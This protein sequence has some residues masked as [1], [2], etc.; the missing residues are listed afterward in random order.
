MPEINHQLLH[1]YLKDLAGDA[2][3]QFAPVYL[4]FGEE[5]LVKTAYAELL[6]ALLPEKNRSANFYPV[7]GAVEN[8]YEVIERVNT[9][10]LIPGTKVVALL[11]SRIFYATQDKTRLIENSKKAY[12]DDNKI[13]AA[14][15]LLSL[16]GNLSLSYEDVDR[17][18]RKKTLTFAP[19]QIQSDDWLDDLIEYCRQNQL[20]IPGPA[21][22]PGAL[23]KAIKNGFPRNNHLVITTDVVDKR[24][25]LYKALKDQGVVVDCRVPKGD[26]RADRM[27]QEDVLRAK[28]A[29]VIEPVNKKVEES[30]YAALLDMTGFDLRT[31]CGNL[32]KLVDYVGQRNTITVK[33]VTSVLKRT[34][35]D[36]IY[37]L[38]NAIADRQ[39]SKTLFFVNT[40]LAGGFH[41]L[42]I[43]AAIINQVRKLLLAKD[44]ATSPEA[45][46]WYA[47][48][49]Y[50]VF[51]QKMM[52][53]ILAYDQSLRQTL[54]K[55]EHAEIG[56]EDADSMAVRG[57]GKKKKKIKTDLMLARNPKNVY[58]VYQL[59]K[60][61][62]HFSKTELMAAVGYLNETDVQLKTSSQD[63]K[64]I[65]ERLVLRICNPQNIFLADQEQ[66]QMGF[67]RQQEERLAVR[68]ITWR[69]EKLG[70]P[71]PD[72]AELKIQASK[73]VAEAHRIARERGRNVVAIIKDL[74]NDIKK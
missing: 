63:P 21:D 53:S 28:M 49:S 71:I 26:R 48:I 27:A 23:Q 13:K 74:V 54:E 46:G 43:L 67:F 9:F 25:G 8:I 2:E 62:A 20:D 40:L 55:W 64:L 66:G 30:A 24:L 58:P 45:K 31:F 65:L 60:K 29:E 6:D 69:Y 34:K 42:Q 41:P 17:S 70:K 18:N 19:D 51:Q 32:E 22:H 73:I 68:F 33:D 50:N 61:S 39:V 10:S 15:Y 56:A 57:K 44:Y 72:A 5:L 12:D 47:G 37:D 3:K 1:K 38:T 52:P 14:K 35:Q 4:F 59:L 36:P 7:E 16:M 11:E